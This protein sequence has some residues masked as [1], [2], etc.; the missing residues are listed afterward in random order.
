M[1]LLDVL[2]HQED[3]RAFMAELVGRL[4]PG[5][6]VVVTVPAGSHLWSGWDVAL[7]HHRRYDRALF[8]R[9]IDGLPL[10]IV[11]LDYLFPELVPLALLRKLRMRPLP[12]DGASV[13]AEF[14]V[15]P[16]P[17][18]ELLYRIGSAS[19]RLRRLWPAGTS[20]LA[21]LRLR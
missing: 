11:A 2:E 16:R 18:N 6:T 14:P 13:D 7:G 21:V 20:L 4:D 17:A 12:R 3:D 9:A 10:T 1:T 15:L 5:A 19:L 8:R